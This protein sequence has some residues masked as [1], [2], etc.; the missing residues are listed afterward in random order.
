MV[1]VGS[2]LSAVYDTHTYGCIHKSI[3]TNIHIHTKSYI[4]HGYITNSRTE[5]V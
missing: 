1:F 5:Y 2:C 4:S 3:F